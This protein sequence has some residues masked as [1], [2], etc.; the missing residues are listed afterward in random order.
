M[1]PLVGSHLY[2]KMSSQT[3]FDTLK[4]T[5]RCFKTGKNVKTETGAKSSRSLS[6]LVPG[7]AF[8]KALAKPVTKRTL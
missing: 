6:I 3:R 4:V 7:N 2:F 5:S 1:K 8:G